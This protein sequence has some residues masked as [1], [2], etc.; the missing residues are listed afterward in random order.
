MPRKDGTGPR[1]TSKKGRGLGPCA[2]PKVTPEDT[3]KPTKKAG[4]PALDG[5]GPHGLRKA[6]RGPAARAKQTK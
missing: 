3:T 4:V 2:E 1:G 6:G 5:T